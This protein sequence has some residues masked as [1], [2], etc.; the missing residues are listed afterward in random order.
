MLKIKCAKI[1]I[2]IIF[3]HL[4]KPFNVTSISYLF[5]AFVQANI[6]VIEFFSD[7]PIFEVIFFKIKK[8]FFF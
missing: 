2:Y 6:C 8:M 5:L 1:C 3:V 4:C 7:K